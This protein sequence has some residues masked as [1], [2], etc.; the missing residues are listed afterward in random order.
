MGSNKVDLYLDAPILELHETKKRMQG[1]SETDQEEVE[2]TV[3]VEQVKPDG[4][5]RGRV[6]QAMSPMSSFYN[7]LGKSTKYDIKPGGNEPSLDSPL[8]KMTKDAIEIKEMH[9]ED[10]GKH[11]NI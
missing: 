6:D 5:E 4:T 2:E 11:L 9:N 8:G 7:S 3:S 10:L 1:S